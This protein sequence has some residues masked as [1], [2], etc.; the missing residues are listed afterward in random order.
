VSA[1]QAFQALRRNIL[2]LGYDREG[3]SLIVAL[4]QSGCTVT[5]QSEKQDDLSGYDL[6][7]SFGYRHIIR[8]RS[9]DSANAP[10]INLHVSL[11]PHNRGAHPNFWAF[12]E[13]TPHGV[14]IHLVDAGIDTGPILFQREVRFRPEEDSF[15]LTHKRLIAEIES[16]F[17]E[18]LDDILL[19]P[20]APQPQTGKGSVHRL[21][22]LPKDFP[23]WDT[24]IEDYLARQKPR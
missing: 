4:E 15:A 5:H 19:R 10:I 24:R 11:L 6:V 18:H 12:A 8:Q 21:A 14:T 23:G 9:I 13:G 7:V 16:L 17:V 3:T 2:F 22:D 20:L 1:D